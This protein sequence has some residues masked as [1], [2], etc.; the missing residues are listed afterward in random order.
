MT[1]RARRTGVRSLVFAAAFV[2]LSSSAAIADITVGSRAPELDIAKTESGKSF[3]LKSYRGKWLFVTFGGSWCKPCKKE[4]PAWDKIA[5]GYKGK[6]TF[7]AINIDNDPAKGKKFNNELKLKNLT[8]VY[9]PAKSA[10]ADDQYET[11]TFPSTFVIDPNGI[12]RHI[13]KGFSSGD[14]DGMKS[15]IGELLGD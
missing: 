3:K 14:V 8:R 7:V 1:G 12:V 5:P 10:A 2:A 4:L 6:L 9:L 13:H 15:K 11:G